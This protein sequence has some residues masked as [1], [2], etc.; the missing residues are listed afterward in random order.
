[1]GEK[2]SP[3]NPPSALDAIV[4]RVLTYNPKDGKTMT[5][6]KRQQGKVS[7]AAAV[8]FSRQRKPPQDSS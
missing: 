4:D 1:M 2:E 8:L 6:R 7:E 5:K 3:S